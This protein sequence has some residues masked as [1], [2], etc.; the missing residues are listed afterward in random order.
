MAL[1]RVGPPRTNED[2][3]AA[4]MFGDAVQLGADRRSF[5]RARAPIDI[6]VI[7]CTE[8]M[9]P[10]VGQDIGLLTLLVGVIVG[11]TRCAVLSKDQFFFKM[12]FMHKRLVPRNKSD[13]Q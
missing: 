7:R 10:M 13:S 12:F 6:P 2:I 11:S 8:L 4:T 9:D 5:A 1:T 3:A